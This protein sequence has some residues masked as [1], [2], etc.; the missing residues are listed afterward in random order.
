MSVI[1]LFLP[2]MNLS[3]V[4]GFQMDNSVVYHVFGAIRGCTAAAVPGYPGTHSNGS[5]GR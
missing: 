5:G 4:V 1:Y 2:Y 3:Q